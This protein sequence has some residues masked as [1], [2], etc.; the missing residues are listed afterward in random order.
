MSTAKT[1]LALLLCSL[2]AQP[3]SRQCGPPAYRCSRTDQAVTQADAAPKLDFGGSTGANTTLTDSAYNNVAITR[4]TDARTNPENPNASYYVG[5]GGSSGKNIW[6][7]D[8]TLLLFGDTGGEL[9]LM[10]FDP[11]AKRCSPVLAAS[12]QLF[13][14]QAGVFSKTEAR[15]YY[16]FAWPK[17]FQ[18]SPIMIPTRGAPTVGPP[19]VDFTPALYQ[20]SVPVWPG[21]GQSVALGAVIKPANNN[22]SGWLFQAITTGLTNGVAEPLWGST[23]LPSQSGKHRVHDGTVTWENVGNSTSSLPYVDVGGVEDRDRYIAESVSFDGAQDTGGWALVYD[24]QQNVIY[25][26]NTWS[27][28]ET[29]FSYSEGAWIST[30]VGK[31]TSDRLIWHENQLGFDGL[32][33]VLDIAV[34]DSCRQTTPVEVWEPGK[35]VVSEMYPFSEGHLVSGSSHIVNQDGEND[36][37]AIRSMAKLGQYSALWMPAPCTNTNQS[38]PPYPHPP[39]FPVF[40]THLSWNYNAGEDQEPLIGTAISGSPTAE[41]VSPWEYELIGI[42]TC[43]AAP[44]S[45][46]PPGY[47][48]GVI[49]RFG[50]TFNFKVRGGFYDSIASGAVSQTGRYYSLTSVGN[51]TMGRS[52]SG[53]ARSD[54]LVYQLQ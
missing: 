24:R 38:K 19:I 27:G 10:R 23:V 16:D 13:Q 47:P 29:D 48:Q 44:R 6:N 45:P 39:C 3:Q 1:V 40:D 49:W 11:R 41:A 54:V 35:A 7:T 32:H 46:C 5:L 12:A 2:S 36:Y 26:Y 18:V 15:T 43:G 30:V 4:C 52:P 14:V 25:Q 53:Q 9:F 42:P 31:A 51:G 50:R 34:C 33:Y 22:P 28:I 8:D 37:F 20:S 17:S 21:A